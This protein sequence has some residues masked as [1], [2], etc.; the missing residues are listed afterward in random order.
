MHFD[1]D[2]RVFVLSNWHKMQLL[3]QIFFSNLF[4]SIFS[5]IVRPNRLHD[6]DEGMF[7]DNGCYEIGKKYF[8]SDHSNGCWSTE[9]VANFWWWVWNNFKCGGLRILAYI[10]L[11]IAIRCFG[12]YNFNTLPPFH[13]SIKFCQLLI[14]EWFCYLA[15]MEN[16]WCMI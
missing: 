15:V 13:K 7:S 10:S 5:I 6:S 4:D 12:F 2:A 16:I 9:F 11:N 14:P 8:Y 1:P 3:W